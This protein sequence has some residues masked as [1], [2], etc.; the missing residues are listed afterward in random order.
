M[1]VLGDSHAAV[2][3]KVKLDTEFCSYFWDICSVNGATVSG[4]HNPN[5]ITNTAKWFNYKVKHSSHCNLTSIIVLLGEVDCGFLAWT[6][7]ER[8]CDEYAVLDS[9]EKKYREFL[10]S[11]ISRSGASV[12]VVSAPLPTITDAAAQTEVAQLRRAINATREQKT[13]LTLKF[14]EKIRSSGES[15]GFRFVDCDEIINPKTG[16]VDD[17]FLNKDPSDHHY[18]STAY[19]KLICKRLSELWT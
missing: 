19:A 12:F 13:S 2:F 9:I 15:L 8:G 18:D 11:I 4:I 3:E 5:S 14:N 16:Y 1:L 6:R 17:S 10:K 7:I